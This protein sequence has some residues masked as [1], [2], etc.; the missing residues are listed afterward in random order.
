MENFEQALNDII[1]SYKTKIIKLEK[2]KHDLS[3]NELE[4]QLSC[5]NDSINIMT[6]SLLQRGMTKNEKIKK[7]NK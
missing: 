3:I 5:Y 2:N 1:E 4:H 7:K 6:Y